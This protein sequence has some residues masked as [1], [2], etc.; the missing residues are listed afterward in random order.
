[1]TISGHTRPTITG[2]FD[3]PVGV[4][5][6][7]LQADAAQS[8]QGYRVR[9][10]LSLRSELFDVL[11]AVLFG[12]FAL[13]DSTSWDAGWLA[14]LLSVL[15]VAPLA[16]RQRAPVLTLVVMLGA[17]IGYGRVIPDGFP[18]GGLGILVGMFTVAMLRPRKVAAAMAALAT[19]TVVVAFSG[20]G[21]EPLWPHMLSDLLFPVGA[22]GLGDATRRWA[23]RGEHRAAEAARAVA[24]ERVRIARDLHDVVAHH[25]SVISLHAGLAGY[26]IG[27]DLPAARTAIGNVEDASREALLDMRRLLDV[28]RVDREGEIDVASQPGLDLLDDLV[29]RTRGAG[30]TVGLTVTGQRSALTPGLELCAYRIVQEALTNVLKHAGPAGAQVEVD[31]GERTLTVRVVDNGARR[32][33]KPS[34]SAHGL[35]GMRE[36]VELYGGV[37]T[38][39][40]KPAGGFAVVARIPFEAD[41]SAE[42][43]V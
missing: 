4:R 19:V 2:S 5:R 31:F 15:A 13:A 18:E 21:V 14:D 32:P 3:T 33:G 30:L 23:R 8:T 29:A 28:L 38:A 7:A 36:R 35:R 20:H 25:M 39:G 41:S 11:L 16:F 1:M 27:A 17:V 37:L 9:V 40:P 12:G 10:R 42:A 43:I 6:I 24:D 26:V 34:R 22:W